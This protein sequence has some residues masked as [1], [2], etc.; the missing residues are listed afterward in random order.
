MD[1][2]K[3]IKELTADLKEFSTVKSSIQVALIWT[4]SAF[5]LVIGIALVISPFRSGVVSQ[6]A[7][8]PRFALEVFFGILIVFLASWS[9]LAKSIPGEE[10]KPLIIKLIALVTAVSLLIIYSFANPALSVS[11]IGKRSSCLTEGLVYGMAL[12]T[13]LLFLAKNRAPFSLTQIAILSSVASTSLTAVIMHLSCMYE[14]LHILIYHISPVLII[15][16]FSIVI[17]RVVIR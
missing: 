12:S 11:M 8:S 17:A 16:I 5:I 10:A 4:F 3:L 2:N 15:S 9:V 14:P 7:S 13:S 6:L 1:K